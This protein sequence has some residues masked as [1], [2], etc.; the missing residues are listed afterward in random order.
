MVIFRN[1]QVDYKSSDI[2]IGR[3]TECNDLSNFSKLKQRRILY[4]QGCHGIGKSY[5]IQWLE[6]NRWERTELCWVSGYKKVENPTEFWKLIC[7]KWGIEAENRQW[8][9]AVANRCRKLAPKTWVIFLVEI[10]PT[11]FQQFDWSPIMEQLYNLGQVIVIF[12]AWR[13]YPPLP[14]F[15]PSKSQSVWSGTEE[16]DDITAPRLNSDPIKVLLTAFADDEVKKL[17]DSL[18]TE[19]SDKTKDEI[20]QWA[21]SHPYALQI[22][23][24]LAEA[25]PKH[26]INWLLRD[27]ENLIDEFRTRIIRSLPKVC[28][29]DDCSRKKKRD[30]C[31]QCYYNH[32]NN[33]NTDY[34]ED[35]GLTYGDN[36][37]KLLFKRNAVDRIRR[38][39][40]SI[41][42]A[43]KVNGS[44]LGTGFGVQYR[45]RIFVITCA[46]ILGNNN[47]KQIRVFK[48]GRD[49]AVTAALV[50]PIPNSWL[51]K[52]EGPAEQDVAVLKI[53]DENSFVGLPEINGNSEQEISQA[54]GYGFPSIN[55]HYG[56]W[57]ESIN[58]A[59]PLDNGFVQV[60]VKTGS[61][62]N[63]HSGTA[64]C[65]VVGHEELIVG[66]LHAGRGSNEAWVIPIST[67]V[68]VLENMTKQEEQHE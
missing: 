37:V 10:N 17:L 46:H 52:W 39:L 45:D 12:E 33:E 15:P 55:G 54:C 57:L 25:D 60:S 63:G 30:V 43:I 31:L 41:T 3:T 21:G 56:A 8:Y 68:S 19:I 23:C 29:R 40:L 13:S 36:L 16:D 6:F 48:R 53:D 26:T 51:A 44:I 42:F 34:F 49:Y 61:V 65:Q 50:T 38:L 7:K 1:C 24:S 18:P 67:V 14:R 28:N 64:I 35:S 59:N 2:F 62:M 20:R 11:S 47:E 66:M 5:L 4:L 32:P 22:M 9:D 27:Q 58:T